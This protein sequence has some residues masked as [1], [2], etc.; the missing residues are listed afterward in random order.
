MQH[1]KLWKCHQCGR[2]FERQGQSHSCKLL[3]LAQH[4][5]NKPQ[6]KLLY[7]KFKSAIKQ[8]IGSF[9]IESSECCIH[10]VSTFTFATAKIF[11]DKIETHFGL[12]RKIKS[13]RMNQ[14]IQLS[15]NR[16]LYYVTITAPDEIDDT[17]MEWI[18]EAEHKKAVKAA[19]V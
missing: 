18:A 5:E 17:L 8:Q 13:K 1:K 14:C 3:P 10:F 11:K 15:A 9:K 19:R 7:E 6:G 16:Y 4:F 2:E 12:Y